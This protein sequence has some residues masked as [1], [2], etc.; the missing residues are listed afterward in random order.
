MHASALIP[1][2]FFFRWHFLLSST[3]KLI[4]VRSLHVVV[5]LPN[6]GLPAGYQIFI[7]TPSCSGRQLPPHLGDGR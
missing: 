2:S 1:Q 7:T 5:V 4:L 6:A 3:L